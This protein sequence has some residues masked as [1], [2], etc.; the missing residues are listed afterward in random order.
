MEGDDG[1]FW[2]HFS[3]AIRVERSEQR[4]RA[5]SGAEIYVGLV[6]QR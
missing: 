1:E 6:D 4:C 3:T 5:D 2:D